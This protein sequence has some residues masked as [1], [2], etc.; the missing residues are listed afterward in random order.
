MSNNELSS[1]GDTWEV[2]SLTGELL[3]RE[4]EL[5]INPIDVYSIVNRTMYSKL[6][7]EHTGKRK[8]R[9]SVS[10]L[11]LDLVVDK[12]LTIPSLSIFCLLGQKVSYRNIIYT[13]TREL[14]EGSGYSRQTV[15]NS[16]SELSINGFI[17]ECRNSLE[18]RDDRLILISPLYFFLG[19]YPHRDNLIKDWYS[20]KPGAGYL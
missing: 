12:G 2:D 1:N 20:P 13:T 18:G 14:I 17:R 16:L 10:P 6:V 15:S 8:Y 19:Y 3:Q 4:E 5:Y 9:L 7:I 11:L